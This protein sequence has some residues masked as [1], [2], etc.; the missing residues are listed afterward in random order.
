MELMTVFK[1]ELIAF[2]ATAY[3]FFWVIIEEQEERNGH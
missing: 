3:L 2:I 1:P